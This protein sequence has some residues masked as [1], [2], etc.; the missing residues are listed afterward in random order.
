MSCL[1]RCAQA[2]V[3]SLCRVPSHCAPHDRQTGHWL[4][5]GQPQ[6]RSEPCLPPVSMESV[7]SAAWR[8]LPRDVQLLISPDVKH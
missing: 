3:V 4:R 8:L 1:Q 7:D 5:S 6:V 2:D